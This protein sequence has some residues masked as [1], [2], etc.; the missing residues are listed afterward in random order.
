MKY[1]RSTNANDPTAWSVQS[2]IVAVATYPSAFYFSDG[3]LAL[4]YRE[5]DHTANWVY[6]YSANN[7]ANWT[8]AGAAVIDGTASNAWYL[9]IRQVGDVLHFVVTWEDHANALGSPDPHYVRRYGLYYF[10][11]NWISDVVTY[12]DGTTATSAAFPLTKTIFDAH[13]V[14]RAAASPE[15]DE[16]PYITI[17]LD[18]YPAILSVRGNDINHTVS[19][20]RRT[21]SSAWAAPV[22]IC[23]T[24]VDHVNDCGLVVNTAVN[25]WTAYIVRKGSSG[26]AGDADTA[27]TAGDIGGYVNEYRS[28][29][30]GATWTR[31]GRVGTGMQLNFVTEV[32]GGIAPVK[33]LAADYIDIGANNGHIV[34][35]SDGASESFNLV[36]QASL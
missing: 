31:K 5:G 36:G 22:Q 7:G 35:W 27:T 4:I 30:N 16:E 1:V 28:T 17:G 34:S 24:G 15:Y 19:F 21:S 13:C 20:V 12:S 8:A 25:N 33:Y 6:A 29:D 18:G 26:I 10:T 2:D 14:V 11:W 3:L 9:C 23:A 32:R